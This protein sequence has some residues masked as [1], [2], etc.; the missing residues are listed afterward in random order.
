MKNIIDHTILG[1]ENTVKEEF[2]DGDSLAAIRVL[3]PC[4]EK[5]HIDLKGFEI[6]IVG[7]LEFKCS[8]CGKITRTKGLWEVNDRR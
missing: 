1:E 3:C 4:G 2:Q 6:N 5:L 8:K 7:I